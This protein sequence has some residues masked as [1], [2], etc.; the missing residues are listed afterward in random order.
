MF[1]FYFLDGFVNR[2]ILCQYQIQ[3][4]QLRRTIHSS[5]T[6]DV[7][8]LSFIYLFLH[9]SDCWGGFFYKIFSIHIFN[10]NPGMNDM[11]KLTKF[12]NVFQRDVMRIK[13]L[14]GL[15]T[16]NACNTIWF[17]FFEILTVLDIGPKINLISHFWIVQFIK[18]AEFE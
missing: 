9:E 13:I 7:D 15:D 17:Q 12:F 18:I 1:C 10:I 11:E 6:M 2:E 8:F 5:W 16:D 14:F 4:Y 3:N